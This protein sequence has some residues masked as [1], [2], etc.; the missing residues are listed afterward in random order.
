MQHSQDIAL[1]IYVLTM[2]K[3]NALELTDTK[4]IYPYS[5]LTLLKQ[6]VLDGNIHAYDLVSC[7]V[8][9]NIL[10]VRQEELFLIH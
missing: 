4:S 1:G 10:L 8:M 5:D 2:L 3:D 6:D 7:R 9:V